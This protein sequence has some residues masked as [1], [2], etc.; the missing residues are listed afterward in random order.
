[1]SIAICECGTVIDTDLDVEG[2]CEP[3]DAF[4]CPACRDY[5]DE[6]NVI[7]ADSATAYLNHTKGM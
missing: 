4:L 3:I 2:F 7:Q 6:G 5:D 1:M